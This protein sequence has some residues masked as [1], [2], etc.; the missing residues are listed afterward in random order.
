MHHSPNDVG[1]AFHHQM[2][3]TEP[4]YDMTDWK[5]RG[6]KAMLRQHLTLLVIALALSASGCGGRTTRLL[7]YPR[8]ILL[9]GSGPGRPILTG[10]LRPPSLTTA[11]TI[12]S[13]PPRPIPIRSPV[14]YKAPAPRITGASLHQTRKTSVLA[15]R[16]GMRPSLPTLPH[17]SSS[18]VRS[19]IR[20][21]HG[22]LHQFLQH[23][24]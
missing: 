12:F 5:E 21:G 19:H 20:S 8:Q 15:S 11:P 24:L 14:S 16:C 3:H 4:S 13:I 1:V 7:W 6:T 10:L 2:P 17:A 22:H 9:R 23:R 18:M